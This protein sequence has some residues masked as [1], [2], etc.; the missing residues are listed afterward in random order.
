MVLTNATIT[1]YNRKYDK[2][3][4][5]DVWNRTVI[6]G[7]HVYINHKAQLMESGLKSAD[8]YKIRIPTNVE[9]VDQYL[10]PEEYAK[11]DNQ[12]ITGRFR[13]MITLSWEIVTRRL[14][15]RQIYQTYD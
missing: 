14:R 4:G 13:T 3:T 5:F 1:I 2:P 7:V 11:M 10:P 9:N 6:H 15:S 8:I 12:G